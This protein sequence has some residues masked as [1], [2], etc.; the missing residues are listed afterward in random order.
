MGHPRLLFVLAA[1]FVACTSFGSADSTRFRSSSADAKRATSSRSPPL[2]EAGV[3]SNEEV[4]RSRDQPAV[5]S[6]SGL[7][8]FFDFFDFF[9]PSAPVASTSSM[10]AIDALSPRRSPSLM[11]RV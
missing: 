1:G 11:M 10:I 8:A 4:T 3:T 6:A 9:S 2:F 5:A 7:A